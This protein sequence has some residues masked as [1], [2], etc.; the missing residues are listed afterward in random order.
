MGNNFAN[1]T[2]IEKKVDKSTSY[3]LDIVQLIFRTYI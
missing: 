3:I 2:A 1:K